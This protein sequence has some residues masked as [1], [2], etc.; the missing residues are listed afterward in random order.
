MIAMTKAA[1]KNIPILIAK[2]LKPGHR[3]LAVILSKAHWL[4]ESSVP[5]D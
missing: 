1:I 2:E 4:R 3:E 5:A